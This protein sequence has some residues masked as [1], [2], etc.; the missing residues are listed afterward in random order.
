[1]ASAENLFLD[2]P[3]ATCPTCTHP[4]ASHNLEL[5]SAAGNVGCI[6]CADGTCYRGQAAD[7]EDGQELELDLLTEAIAERVAALLRDEH[8]I[9]ATL[10]AETGQAIRA[11]TGGNQSF[12]WMHTIP[13][14][15][16]DCIGT[17]WTL[18]PEGGLFL[19]LRNGR[20]A[21]IWRGMLR[22]AEGDSGG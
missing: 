19:E 4:E 6:D 14:A 18:T 5:V 7:L 12:Y 3:A 2:G 15:G 9:P 16:P 10:P 22:P 11:A 21:T 1:M 8:V 17:H 20:G 13:L